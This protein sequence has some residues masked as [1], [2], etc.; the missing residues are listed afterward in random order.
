MLSFVLRITLALLSIPG[1]M[2]HE[3]GHQVMCWLTG[4]RVLKVRYF[5][6]GVPPGY[7][8]HEMPASVW[9]H[10]LIAAGPCLVNSVGAFGLGLLALQGH[11][12]VR[13]PAT[14]KVLLTWLALAVGLHAFPSL[15]DANAV[16]SGLWEARQGWITRLLATPF[17]ALLYVL[18]F[19]RWAW[20]DLAFAVALAWWLPRLGAVQHLSSWDGWR[21]G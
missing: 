4:T 18:A 14:T 21:V 17:A 6:I 5:R 7:V 9:R 8:L 16:M 12:W 15:E 11:A 2:A 3:L 13:D 1:V 19:A 10:L 20:L